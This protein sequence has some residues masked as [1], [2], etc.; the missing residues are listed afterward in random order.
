MGAGPAFLRSG[1]AEGAPSFPAFFAG[2]VGGEALNPETPLPDSFRVEQDGDF[3]FEFDGDSEIGGLV[4][5]EIACG[6]GEAALISYGVMDWGRSIECT[7]ARAV[8]DVG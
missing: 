7:V 2:R 6:D 1:N 3:A 4:V 5:V 8:E